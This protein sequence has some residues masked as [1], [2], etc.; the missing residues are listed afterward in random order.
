MKKSKKESV[1]KKY[2]IAMILIFLGIILAVISFAW[3]T[4]ENNKIYSISGTA[5]KGIN[6]T[7]SQNEIDI[8]FDI[9]Y[10]TDGQLNCW[11]QEDGSWGS[12]YDI[13]V[14]NNSKHPVKNWK[15][16]IKA[17]NGYSID[18]SWNGLFEEH[19]NLITV[20][21][22]PSA[23]NLTII[24][25]DK[26][27][28]GFVLYTPKLL[29]KM[30]FQLEVNFIHEL[31][32]NHG[33]LIG[34]ASLFIGLLVL[35]VI[36]IVDHQLKKADEKI[37]SLVK[38]CAKFIDIRD[39]YTKM[40]SF[41]V[42]EYSKK[43]AHQMGFDANF[44]KN[45]YYLGMLHDTGKVLIPREILC[46]PGKLTDEEW[47]EMKKHTLYGGELLTDLDGLKDFKSVALHHHERYDGKGYPEGLEKD[48]IPI[49]ARIVCVA[50]SFDAMHTNRSY[51]QR[52]SDEVILLELKKNR[53]TQFDP[54]VVDALIKI[55][56]RG[57][58]A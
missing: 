24:A 37:D 25:H 17:P 10:R 40:H 12:Q 18:S 21:P 19:D 56:E 29:N 58:I 6:E 31:K 52:L 41:N 36:S 26:V 47:T 8:D 22:I 57:E 4:Y 34:L 2:L 44:Q 50:D 53:G 7:P 13:F 38:I 35:L 14:Y 55:I 51:R 43:I 49:E 32:K 27:R 16:D 15:L 45:I 42:A 3:M 48:E 28:I 33:F 23:M 11:Q 20:T 30:D 39:E 54:E 46:K 5:K 9:P 1:N